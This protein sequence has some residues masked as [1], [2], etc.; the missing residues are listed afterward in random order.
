[1]APA[2]GWMGIKNLEAVILTHSHPDHYKGLA[3]ILNHFQVKEFWS[4]IRMEYLPEIIQK[5][6]KGKNI[7]VIRFP[8]G[9]TIHHQSSKD[10][11]SVFV[12]DQSTAVVNDRSLVIFIHDGD[13]SLLL[14]GDLEEQGVKNFIH[15]S[16][17]K[18][19]SL[20]KLPHHGSPHSSPELLL[21]FLHPEI[22]FATSPEVPSVKD[23]LFSSGNPLKLPPLSLNNNG[24]P[25]SLRFIA[26]K[27]GWDVR[28]W[29][30]GLFR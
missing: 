1:M 21:N 5:P 26:T 6:L 7:P 24:S 29:Q 12:P 25:A 18:K 9:W 2:L 22:V 14:T 30:R 10:V 11:F 23:L 20:L 17:Y 13:N 15:A 28:Y 27:G 3:F 16:I 4:A 19:A 8:E